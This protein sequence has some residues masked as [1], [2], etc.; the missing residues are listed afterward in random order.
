[1]VPPAQVGEGTDPDDPNQSLSFQRL[2]AGE[3][4]LA[5]QQLAGAEW[6]H[7]EIPDFPF[8]ADDLAHLLFDLK[9]KLGMDWMWE[10]KIVGKARAGRAASPKL[11]SG[12]Q[13]VN[14]CGCNFGRG[15]ADIF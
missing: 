10:K 1:M 15:A 12:K 14:C 9:M 13:L 2:G 4:P 5:L 6:D 11:D 8:F 3:M 7:I